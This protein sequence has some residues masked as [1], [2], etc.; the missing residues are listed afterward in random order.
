MLNIFTN[1][2]DDPDWTEDSFLME[3]MNSRISI[4]EFFGLLASDREWSHMANKK[5]TE[6]IIE[7]FDKVYGYVEGLSRIDE[8]NKRYQKQRQKEK[9]EKYFKKCTKDHEHTQ[10]CGG[11]LSEE[12]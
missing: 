1:I 2:Q 9:D 4:S 11:L 8:M 3:L 6:T 10:E 7:L 5:Q 12:E